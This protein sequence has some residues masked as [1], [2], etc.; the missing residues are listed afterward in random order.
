MNK[1]IQGFEK[2]YEITDNGFVISLKTG[3]CS[4]GYKNKKG[5]LIFDFRR[6]NG[7]CVPIH[8]LVATAFIPNPDKK[9]QVNHIDGDKTNNNVNNLEWVTNGE[10]QIHA[11][12]NKLQK[13]EFNHPNSKLKLED[14]LFIKRNYLLGNKEF[15]CQPLARRFNVSNSTIKQIIDGKSYKNVI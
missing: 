14:V 13:G 11:F 15:G 3:K 4:K 7:K 2:L 12:K 9:P 1:A 8:R 10:N 5:Y 6:Q